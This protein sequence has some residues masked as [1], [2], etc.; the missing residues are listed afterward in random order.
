MAFGGIVLPTTVFRLPREAPATELGN[1]SRNKFNTMIRSAT[2]TER[3]PKFRSVPT[4]H[5][6]FL[7]LH[8][9]D[10]PKLK[11]EHRHKFVRCWP[12]SDSINL[13]SEQQQNVESGAQ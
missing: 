2:S 9:A 1:Y 13:A 5:L 12:K 8:D 7:G 11:V 4:Y 10:H 6:R 3:M